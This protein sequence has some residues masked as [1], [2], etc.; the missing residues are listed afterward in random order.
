M[1]LGPKTI[2]YL[3]DLILLGEEAE[4]ADHV[5][6]KEAPRDYWGAFKSQR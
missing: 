2:S 5:L 3:K 6:L 4:L 1:I